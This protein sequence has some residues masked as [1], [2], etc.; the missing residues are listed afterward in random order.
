MPSSFSGPSSSLIPPCRVGRHLMYEKFCTAYDAFI[1]HHDYQNKV[2]REIEPYIDHNTVVIDCGCGSGRI[3]R[4]LQNK[5]KRIMAF[6]A[7]CSMVEYMANQNYENTYCSVARLGEEFQLHKQSPE[8]F[9]VMSDP[10]C[11][12]SKYSRTKRSLPSFPFYK[13]TSPV[14]PIENSVPTS[15]SQHQPKNR[16]LIPKVSLAPNSSGREILKA[17]KENYVVIA[18]WSLSYVKQDNWGDAMWPTYVSNVIASWEKTFSPNYIIIF[19]T[20]GTG[21]TQ[22]KRKGDILYHE[23]GFRLNLLRTDYAF[24]SVLEAKKFLTFFF[25]QVSA[26]SFISKLREE[27]NQFILSE[28]TGS[29]IKNCRA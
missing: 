8:T 1:S 16:L 2:L 27:N 19:E 15:H 25:G 11:M 5:V 4:L 9:S 14:G 17:D 24:S 6:D 26:G 7:S 23:P 28:V 13:W 12:L 20:L 29:Y 22:A 10:F 21:N 3:T 18:A